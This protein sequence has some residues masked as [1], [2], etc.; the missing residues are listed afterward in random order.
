M[1]NE[2]KN[3]SKIEMLPRMPDVLKNRYENTPTKIHS[4][5]I[6]SQNKHSVIIKYPP[7]EEN[8]NYLNINQ[9]GTIKSKSER[10]IHKKGKDVACYQPIRRDSDHAIE[11]NGTTPSNKTIPS[12]RTISHITDSSGISYSYKTIDEVPRPLLYDDDCD[13][14]Y[15]HNSNP[16]FLQKMPESYKDY[17]A[18]DEGNASCR[19]VRPSSQRIYYNDENKIKRIESKSVPMG[20]YIVFDPVLKIKSEIAPSEFHL[21]TTIEDSFLKCPK[22][23]SLQSIKYQKEYNEVKKYLDNIPKLFL[24]SCII[25]YYE[26]NAP[27]LFRIHCEKEEYMRFQEYCANKGV[28]ELVTTNISQPKNIAKPENKATHQEEMFADNNQNS[29]FGSIFEATKKFAYRN[30]SSSPKNNDFITK[31]GQICT[32]NVY[33]KL[34]KNIS[35]EKVNKYFLFVIEAD[36]EIFNKYRLKVLI[37][38]LFASLARLP[39]EC[40]I[41]VCAMIFEDLYFFT[42]VDFINKEGDI[43]HE[44]RVIEINNFTEEIFMPIDFSEFFLPIQELDAKVKRNYFDSIFYQMYNCFHNDWF[45]YKIPENHLKIL[46]MHFLEWIAENQ[47]F[48]NGFKKILFLSTTSEIF[49]EEVIRGKGEKYEKRLKACCEKIIKNKICLDVF[50]LKLSKLKSFLNLTENNGWFIDY[51]PNFFQECDFIFPEKA[52]YFP[53]K[54][55]MF[56]YI[57]KLNNSREGK[58]QLNDH[59]GYNTKYKHADECIHDELR[60][61]LENSIINFKSVDVQ[62]EIRV[63]TDVKGYKI[64]IKNKQEIPNNVEHISLSYL[65]KNYN[66]CLN[67]T[68]FQDIKDFDKDLGQQAQVHYTDEYNRRKCRIINYTC[69]YTTNLKEYYNFLDNDTILA[70]ILRN[71]LIKLSENSFISE[72][73]IKDACVE[74]QTKIQTDY[75]LAYTDSAK[76]SSTLSEQLC[77][78][79]ESQELISIYM[80]SATKKQ[81]IAKKWCDF[82]G[83]NYYE[84]TNFVNYDLYKLTSFLY[85]RF[86]FVNT[87]DNHVIGK[88]GRDR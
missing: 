54:S 1:Y 58:E 45:N 19:Y 85:P 46:S 88:M 36:Q 50:S 59:K 25:C 30:K 31:K 16:K 18:T 34:T 75:V 40:Y 9:T 86:Y 41:G 38:T 21:E 11:N 20:F 70:F 28:Y 32:K 87:I 69:S 8:T 13:T 14:V 2:N 64:L 62:I 7:K 49:C 81:C 39:N 72:K 26:I 80:Y 48:M 52:K 55:S 4:N 44:L 35:E 12:N 65:R 27:E 10:R 61:S 74:D 29:W 43:T 22:C 24:L 15:H 42:L 56:D 84:W 6:E 60:Y 83:L 68:E 37:D 53:D 17:I 78:C 66:I 77:Y 3:L 73:K 33:N 76:A 47:F 57:A 5:V 51:F 63:S 79:P 23:N 82:G 67:I 71:N